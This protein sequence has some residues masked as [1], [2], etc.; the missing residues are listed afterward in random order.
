LKQQLFANPKWPK[1]PA[2][3]S[4]KEDRTSTSNEEFYKDRHHCRQFTCL[5]AGLGLIQSSGGSARNPSP[6]FL[7][8]RKSHI[9]C[10]GLSLSLTLLLSLSFIA[11]SLQ[12]LQALHVICCH[13]LRALSLNVSCVLRFVT[14]CL[15]FCVFRCLV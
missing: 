9:S 11:L 1:L 13:C 15:L 6:G 14:E 12:L 10:L 5:P 8:Q 2:A 4:S 3:R 7:K